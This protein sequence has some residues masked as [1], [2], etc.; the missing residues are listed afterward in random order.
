VRVNA[1]EKS[2]VGEFLFGEAA[3]GGREVVGSEKRKENREDF[4]IAV[5][6]NRVRVVGKTV[7]ECEEERVWTA[8]ADGS[9]CCFEELPANVEF[10]AV[11]S[12]GLCRAVRSA[13]FLHF[14]VKQTTPN[15]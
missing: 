7:G 10:Y 8:G 5:Y 2:F 12:V 4:W 14:L 3:G 6:E 11:S 15:A 1:I 13:F 9:K